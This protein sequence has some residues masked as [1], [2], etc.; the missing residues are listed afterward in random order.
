MSTDFKFKHEADVVRSAYKEKKREDGLTQES[1][2]H[3]MNVS[4]GLI[5]HWFSGRARIPDQTLMELGLMLGFNPVEVRP[6]LQRYYDLIAR[7]LDDTGV[8]EIDALARSLSE[9]E[10]EQAVTYI[11]FL[12]G[13]RK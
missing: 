11:R 1:L 8:R 5:A 2:A 4:Q 7:Q 6:D 10:A 13:Q 3:K 12:V 9:S